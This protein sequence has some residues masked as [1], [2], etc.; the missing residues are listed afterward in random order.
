M[1]KKT[2]KDKEFQQEVLIA[3]TIVEIGEQR[4]DIENLVNQL[5]DAAYEAAKMDNNDYV[6]ELVDMI[7][8]FQEFGEEL[9][10]VELEIKTCAITAKVMA[11][12]GK[13]PKALKACKAVFAKAPDFT[14]LGKEYK[15]LREALAN[16]RKSVKSLRSEMSSSH[17]SAYEK[18]Y[19]KK[20]NKDPKRTQRVDN[21]KKSLEAR[22]VSGITT[23]QPAAKP[24]ESVSASDEARIDAIAAML[25][26][27]RK[28]E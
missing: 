4:K 18:I 24:D 17:M 23:T 12:L 16:A 9:A 21:I 10:A 13:L 2:I 28:G 14:K 8:D 11:R 20:E 6:N 27:E 1:S 25:D 7:A 19:G 22:L 3:E 15:S 26:E 5:S